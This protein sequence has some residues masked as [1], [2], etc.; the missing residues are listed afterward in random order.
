MCVF[1]RV[2]HCHAASFMAAVSESW[3]HHFLSCWRFKREKEINVVC[4][5][6]WK[7][8]KTEFFAR[9]NTTKINNWILR[10]VPLNVSPAFTSCK[11]KL[12]NTKTKQVPQDCLSHAHPH[13][14]AHMFHLGLAFTKILR[15]THLF[16]CCRL[17][18]T[19]MTKLCS[20]EKNPNRHKWM[21]VSN[22]IWELSSDVF[23]KI[24][25]LV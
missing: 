7:D 16:I 6:C 15:Q 1:P 13:A 11:S 24:A 20:C 3:I 17:S 4:P 14:Y 10:T 19:C 25:Q 23:L 12:R 21:L 9:R 8:K 18:D 5:S 22:R 2:I